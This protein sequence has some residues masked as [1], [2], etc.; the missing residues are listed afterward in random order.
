MGIYSSFK[1][2]FSLFIST[3]MVH[4]S[5]FNCASITLKKLPV[6]L[7]RTATHTVKVWGLNGTNILSIGTT[8]LLKKRKS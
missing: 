5:G 8:R 1:S 4:P 3:I 6:S 2:Q 7:F